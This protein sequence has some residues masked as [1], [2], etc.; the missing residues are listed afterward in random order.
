MFLMIL[1]ILK[2]INYTLK[3][4]QKKPLAS[5]LINLRDAKLILLCL[6]IVQTVLLYFFPKFIEISLIYILLN[7]AYSYLLKNIFLV[8]ILSLSVNY[9]IRVYAG[10]VALDVRILVRIVIFLNISLL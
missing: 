5:G 7:I 4:K 3:K 6:I 2:Q 1:L 8:D 10:C 9:L